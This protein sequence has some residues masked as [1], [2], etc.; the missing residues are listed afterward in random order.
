MLRNALD[1]KKRLQNLRYQAKFYILHSLRTLPP[2]QSQFEE[3][4]PFEPD[5]PEPKASG[6][7]T[8]SGSG[9]G[10]AIGSGKALEIA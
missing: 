6:S 5:D 9:S 1:K 4:P 8:G 7:A 3:L 2:E 10:S